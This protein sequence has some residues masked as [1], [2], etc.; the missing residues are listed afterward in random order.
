MYL[1]RLELRAFRSYSQAE[2]ALGRG[3]VVIHGRNGA[4]KTSLL[5]AACM[6]ALGGSPRAGEAREMIRL[7]QDT[8]FVRAEFV[9]GGRRLQVEVGL[10]RSGAR[11]VKLN[12]AVRRRADLIGMTPLQY[13][14]AADLELI[15][16]EPGARRRLLDAELSAT[17]ARYHTLLG[18]YR[19]A[20]EQRNRLLKEV[21]AGRAA[22]QG[23]A[24]WDRALARYGAEV[25]W[26]RGQFVKALSPA[27][28]A[29]HARLTG[30]SQEL[31]IEYRPSVA[32]SDGQGHT[33]WEEERT[34][35]VANLAARLESALQEARTED[36]ARGLTT[37]G[38][39]RDDMEVLLRGVPA[40]AF[41]SQG[42]QRG[43]ALAIRLGLGQVMETTL[44]EQPVLLLDDVLS[45]LDAQHRAGVFAACPRV[46][47][48]IITCC[49]VGTI[50]PEALARAQV[51][52]VRDGQLI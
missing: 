43:C 39:H 10:A 46:E 17:S 30:G 49:E 7:G 33:L 6:A 50:P 11:Q 5:E 48:V 12:G 27:A 36:L 21:R 16:G 15:Q 42:E 34:R 40:R 26:E 13:F 37:V 9:A 2:L 22:I 52:E 45:E 24:P 4:G 51:H 14:S 18:R 44:G 35:M 25:M 23:L 28:A 41:G 8:S 1:A 3:V 32:M 29:A 19:R 20:L 31:M 47:Q 38:P